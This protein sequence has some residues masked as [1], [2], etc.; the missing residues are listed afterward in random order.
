[1]SDTPE[2]RAKD[3]QRRIVWA[4]TLNDENS[5]LAEL[6][7]LIRENDQLLN[8]EAELK[9]RLTECEEDKAMLDWLEQS[10]TPGSFN[11]IG[12]YNSASD[13]AGTLHEYHADKPYWV[14]ELDHKYGESLRHAIREAMKEAK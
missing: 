2:Q 10:I 1:M 12:H 6:A 8:A 11:V 5:L 14:D 13:V 9:M 7:A 4:D 3:L